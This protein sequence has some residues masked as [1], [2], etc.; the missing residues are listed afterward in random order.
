MG[1]KPRLHTAYRRE[2]TKMHVRDENTAPEAPPE[3]R[4]KT[5]VTM[6][7]P[8]HPSRVVTQGTASLPD[9]AVYEGDLVGGV[10]CGR[11]VEKNKQGQIVYDGEW[12]DGKY[13]GTGVFWEK[14]SSK[15]Y[16]KKYDSQV[17]L[18]S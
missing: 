14:V 18:L 8:E 15:K 5:E 12:K 13:E 17:R 6:V 16:I 9:G 1:A 11:G 2:S 4:V 10:P 7:K 3:K